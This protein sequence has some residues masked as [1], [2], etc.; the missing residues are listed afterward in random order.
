[1]NN[2][3]LIIQRE[4]L[5]R[6]KKRSFILTT[7]L[8]PII[9]V[10]FF[11]VVGFIFAYQGEKTRIAVHNASDLEVVISSSGKKTVF[12]NRTES[13]DDLKQNYKEL[14]FDGILYLP[15]VTNMNATWQIQYFS[16]KQLSLTTK[17]SI[18]SKV[19]AQ[20]RRY[21]IKALN[22][23]ENDL[24]S[25]ENTNV[26]LAETSLKV[27]SE[28]ELKETDAT[29][30]A[31]LATVLGTVMGFLVYIVLFVYGMMVMRSVM[32]EKTNR[33]V[34]VMVSSVK[35]FELMLGKII[36]VGG[37]GLTQFLIWVVLTSGLLFVAQLFMP[38][39]DPAQID[40][41]NAPSAAEM[42]DMQAKIYEVL[43]LVQQQNWWLI[44]VVFLFYFL[45]GYFLY[46][47]LFAAVGSAMG[48]DMGESQSLTLPITIPIIL[49]IY[50]MM[51]VVN[52][53]NSSLATW[54]S[55]VPFF[56]PIIMPAR[57][58]FEPAWWELGLS[59]VI[60]LGSAI[61]FVWLSGRIYR[62][63]ILMYGKKITFKELWK[64]LFYKD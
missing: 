61:F 54:S 41:A 15:P 2:L 38:E 12:I 32:E 16:D 64:W 53:P 57:M 36:G 60:L 62:V 56:S 29:N 24:K 3:W 4:Y 40:L 28:G 51:A 1:M 17:E 35:P 63:G 47:S 33:I 11:V 45:G 59:M 14:E 55:L 19:E 50:I 37:V 26:S 42:D 8:T 10:A 5:T 13:L 39:I 23:N 9:M 30:S 34:E 7:I 6:V 22:I 25:I 49:A 18:E 27:D 44:L 52:N 46:A 43:Q 48:D 31:A 21:K 20:L 58:P